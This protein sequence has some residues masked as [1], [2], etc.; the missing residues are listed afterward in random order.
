MKNFNVLEATKHW[1]REP[2]Q[3]RNVTY[4]SE[5]MEAFGVQA[6]GTSVNATTAMRVSAV[7]ASQHSS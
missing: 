7:A 1:T 5:V 6:S 3:V 2:A 4:S